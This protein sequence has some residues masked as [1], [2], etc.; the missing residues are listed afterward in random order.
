MWSGS[1][2]VSV[3]S[4]A[5]PFTFGSTL[6]VIGDTTSPNSWPVYHLYAGH[7]RAPWPHTCIIMRSQRRRGVAAFAC[8]CFGGGGRAWIGWPTPRGVAKNVRRNE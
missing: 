1:M 6:G 3:R 8:V 7:A 4:S 2:V 5:H